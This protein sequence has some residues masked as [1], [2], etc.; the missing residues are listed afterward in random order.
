[1]GEV[2]ASQV[3]DRQ[4]AEQVVDDRSRHL[5]GVVAL[6]DA[7]RLEPG[8][9]EGVDV[10]LQRHAVLQRDRDGDGEVVHQRAEGGAFLVH[11]DEDF[12]Q[13]AVFVFAGPEIDL[14]AADGRLLG[15]SLAAMRRPFAFGGPDDLLDHPFGDDLGFFDGRRLGDGFTNDLY[16][17][18]QVGIIEKRRRQRLRQLRSVP[19]KGVRLQPQPPGQH[20]GLLAVLDGR[21]VGHVD[22]L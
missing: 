9:G 7:R 20:V 5:D 1:M 14:V 18:F 13:P 15:V 17:V 11:V 6:D 22:G 2:V 16:V 21:L 4:F 3:R 12:G 10:F 8:E 19:V